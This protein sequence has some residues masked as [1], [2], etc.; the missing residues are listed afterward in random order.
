MYIDGYLKG[1]LD[2]LKKNIMKDWDF[3]LIVDGLERSGKSSL[4][5]QTACYLDPLFNVTRIVFTCEQF[6]KAI[7]SADKYQ[8]VVWDEAVVGTQATDMTKMARTLQKMAVQIGQKNLFIILVIHS[9]FE[10][11]KYYAVHRTWFLLHTYFISNEKTKSFQRGYFA[12]YDF[13]KKK[14]MYVNDVTRRNYEYDFSPNFR[15]RFV[16]GYGL[17]N[18]TEYLKKKAEIVIDERSI[19]KEG[20]WF[21]VCIDK[22]MPWNEVKPYCS[23]SESW[24]YTRKRQ[25]HSYTP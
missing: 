24:F 1:N 11:K 17:V 15:G 14:K 10:M 19:D 3:W 22:E 16:K 4:A 6:E 12:F 20:V 9:Y 2:I 23:Y 7:L 18:E 5:I 8:A 13:R 21:D 25:L